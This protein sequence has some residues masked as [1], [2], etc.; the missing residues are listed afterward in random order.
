M[1][2]HKDLG[3]WAFVIG[4][5]ALFAAYPLEVLAHITAPNWKNWWAERSRASVTKRVSLLEKEQEKMAKIPEAS[6]AE[7]F[8]M[9]RLELLTIIVGMS[10]HMLLFM[11]YFAVIT[12]GQDLQKSTNISFKIGMFTVISLNFLVMQLATRGSLTKFRR[13]RSPLY[14]KRVQKNIEELKSKLASM[15]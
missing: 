12:L 1:W 13:F 7:S 6:E 15:C 4:I 10:V 5:I 9:W 2:P 11:G 3:W 8:I 14:R